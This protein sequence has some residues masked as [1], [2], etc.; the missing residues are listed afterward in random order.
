MFD[1]ISEN[2]AEQFLKDGMVEV[3]QNTN[4][5]VRLRIFIILLVIHLFILNRKLTLDMLCRLA[6]YSERSITNWLKKIKNDSYA[7]LYDKD[8][9]GRQ[10]ELTADDIA[11]IKE[12]LTD[13]PRKYGYYIWDG[14]SIQHFIKINFGIEYSVRHCQRMCREYF[15]LSL[16]RPRRYPAKAVLF[17]EERELFKYKMLC[18][19]AHIAVTGDLLVT[20]DE[21]HF[22][23]M[24]TIMR[25][26]AERGS[27]P[28]AYSCDTHKSVCLSG[29]GIVN[30]GVF[31]ANETKV[32]DHITYIQ[33]IREFI[34]FLRSNGL[35]KRQKI[36]I[37][38]DNAS[39]HTKAKKMIKENINGEFDD[40]NEYVV[41]VYMPPYSPDL[42]PIELMWRFIRRHVTHNKYFSDVE[43]LRIAITNFLKQYEKENPTLKN[44]FEFSYN[45]DMEIVQK[46]YVPALIELPLGECDSKKLSEGTNKKQ[47]TAR[48]AKIG[49]SSTATNGTR[50]RKKGS[51]NKTT[52]E[53]REFFKEEGIDPDSKEG[54]MLVKPVKKAEKV[55]ESQSIAPY[56]ADGK[57]KLRKV[58]ADARCELAKRQDSG[59]RRGR[60]IS[61][62]V[63]ERK[64]LIL[65]AG[66]DLDSPSGKKLSRALSKRE[67]SL[68]EKAL[69]HIHLKVKVGLKNS[70]MIIL[71]LFQMSSQNM[72]LVDQA[73]QKTR[74]HLIEKIL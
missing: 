28:I 26:W 2:D 53:R 15:K 27:K 24:T 47:G 46:H 10:K 60:P 44:L 11:Q 42:N 49:D 61:I 41:F 59:P 5:R 63:A 12:C 20:Q 51:I 4:F 67:D 58:L 13:D 33:S 43:D 37:V 64:E 45:C 36:Y 66:F 74:S 3:S 38:S 70:S 71:N 25:I 8:N 57:A 39:Y 23:I 22:K 56:S 40:I 1:F 65:G 69:I 32:F 9:P 72:V 68:M 16:I 73:D 19:L 30:N 50:G 17:C 31:F 7:A 62:K 34:K 55:L 35:L 52:A 54:S 14:S 21:A 6:G 29:F 18:I 48:A